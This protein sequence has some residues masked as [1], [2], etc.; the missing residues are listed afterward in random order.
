MIFVGEPTEDGGGPRR[1]FFRFAL[2]A[3]TADPALFTGPAGSHVPIHS[4][5]A[6]LNRLF[7]YVGNLIAASIAQGGPGPCFPEWLYHYICHGVEKCNVGVD[8]TQCDVTKQLMIEVRVQYI[9][10]K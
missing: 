10:V 5:H 7:F 3:A 4:A 1:E 8:D 2:A 6:L 9:V